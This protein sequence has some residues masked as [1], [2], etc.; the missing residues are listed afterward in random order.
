MKF[1]Q[2]NVSVRTKDTDMETDSVF[3]LQYH[4][5]RIVNS[6]QYKLFNSIYHVNR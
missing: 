4:L 6:T 1:A 2:I 3:R 5:N